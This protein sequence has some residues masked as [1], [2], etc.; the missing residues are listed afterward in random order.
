M[1]GVGMLG[2][3]RQEE[4]RVSHR[5]VLYLGWNLKI[6]HLIKIYGVLPCCRSWGFSSKENNPK[7]QLT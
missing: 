3:E 4:P 6:I 5:E 7:S 2:G 1:R